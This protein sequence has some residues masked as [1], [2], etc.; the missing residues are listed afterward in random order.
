MYKGDHND[1][2]LYDNVH[3]NIKG[4]NKLAHSMGLKGNNKN[5]MDMCSVNACQSS[6]MSWT[7]KKVDTQRSTSQ[8]KTRHALGNQ[9]VMVHGT[10]TTDR[11]LVP[12]R[13]VTLQQTQKLRHQMTPSMHLSGPG[14]EERSNDIREKRLRMPR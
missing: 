3:L 7:N 8:Q 12:P 4:A 5:A 9:M 1:G 13:T 6:P 11:A 2:Y 14:H 10:L